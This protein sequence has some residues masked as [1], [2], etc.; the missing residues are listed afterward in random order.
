MKKILG[1]DL[2]TT[3]SCMS[4]VINGEANIITNEEGERTTPSIV[5]FSKNGERIIGSMAKR[6]SAAEPERTAQ[7]IKR[8]IGSKESLNFGENGYIPRQISAMVL[9]KI[10]L[11][12]EEYLGEKIDRAV[13]TVPAYFEDSQRQATK[14]AG[15]IAGLRVERIINE[16]TAAALAYGF[17]NEDE[18]DQIV[19][20]YDFGGGTFDV[21]LLNIESGLIEVL[22]VNGNNELG[23][24]DFDKALMEYIAEDFEKNHDINLLELELEVKQR[25]MDASEKAKIELSSTKK[26]NISIPYITEGPLHIDMD[27][28]RTKF[29]QLTEHLIEKTKEPCEQVLQDANISSSDLDEVILV[30]GTTRIPAVQE[31]VENITGKTPLKSINPDEVVAIGAA[32]QGGVLTGEIDEVILIDAVPLSLGVEV[33]GGLFSKIIEKNTSIPTTKSK[34]FSTAYDN[35]TDVL[36]NVFQGERKIANENK[37]LGRF[38][39]SGI[40]E[41]PRGQAKI[42]VKF[43][44]D[45][46]V[47]VQ[48]SARE[49][50]T[51]KKEEITIKNIDALSEDELDRMIKEAEKYREEDKKRAER[52]N[53]QNEID[54]LLYKIEKKLK[55]EEVSLSNSEKEKLKKAERD[56]K[57][58]L[59]EENNRKVSEELNRI[60]KML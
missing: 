48:A 42:E 41:A 10:K 18:D 38:Q 17:D 23:G 20:V 1:I 40:P 49:K 21:S 60:R 52:I 43:D 35:Q 4:V 25:L 29:N 37:S 15:K 58:L 22:A 36:I 9:Q 30:G 8:K 12:A 55:N 53:L 27:I 16:P 28:T 34:E 39:L 56:L 33:K 45:E 44:I 59:S 47:I 54:H 32:L 3:N 46:N 51:N 13:I 6:K 19:M 24:D 11:D 31:M 14:D 2:G 5:H 7:S 57:S 26:T 50:E